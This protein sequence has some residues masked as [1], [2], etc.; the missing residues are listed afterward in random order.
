MIV[1]PLTE[2]LGLRVPLVQGGMQWVGTPALA[3]AVTNAG[4]LGIL[5]ALTQ[6]TPDALRNAIRETRALISDEIKAERKD[7]YGE[8]AVNITLLPSINP[9]DYEGFTRAALEEG[10][11]IFET[12]GYN[13][14]PVIKLAKQYGAF[15]I[16]KCTSVRHA[17]SAEKLGADMLS[18][19]GFECAGH[20]GEDDIGGLVLMARAAEELK[21]P[22][23]ASGGIAN[24][25]GLA[26]ALALGA[27][28]ANMGTR[29][30]CTKEAEV[31]DNVKRAIVES[32]ERNTTHIFRSLK[33]TARVYN[34]DGGIDRASHS[35]ME[36]ATR[37]PSETDQGASSKAADRDAAPEAAL[38]LAEQ[39]SLPDYGLDAKSTQTSTPP[40]ASAAA[41]PPDPELPVVASR[42]PWRPRATAG[43]L[44]YMDDAIDQA[45]ATVPLAWQAFLT[46]MVDMLL[47]SRTSVWLGFQTGNM[48]QISGNIAQYM[49]PQAQKNGLQT[50]LRGL[51]IMSFVTGSFIGYQAGQRLGHNKRRWMFLSSLI[52]S[53][54]LFGS[55]GILLSQPEHMQPSYQYYPAI[56]VLPAFS[57]GMQGIAAQKLSSPTFAT[58]VAFTATLPQI[59]SDPYLFALRPSVNTRG[60]D[61]RLLAIAMLCLGAGIGETFLYTKAGFSG[62]VAIAAGFKL[63]LAVLWLIPKGKRPP[64][65]SGGSA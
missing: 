52:Q 58:T 49:F 36:G 33:N 8:I 44:S 64:A 18:I 46:G 59:T 45:E 16:H 13:P 2:Q 56:I 12:A 34:H 17:K 6:P 29:F 38:D 26:S 48:V 39:S 31:H 63:L 9:P 37:Q 30:L 4:A 55:A 43:A 35:S 7:K 32:D 62:G 54:L 65:T 20:P 25:Q 47:Y 15:V 27:A 14:G 5:T 28:G 19:D 10:C 1:T 51:S 57:M 42:E 24:G 61:R 21:V 60:R 41:D 22:F 50:L 23:I 11:R 40:P 3:A 53:A